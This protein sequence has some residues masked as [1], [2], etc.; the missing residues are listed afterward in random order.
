MYEVA[1]A[2][3]DDQS[4]SYATFM[5]NPAI[6]EIHFSYP[7]DS[8]PIKYTIKRYI[9]QTSGNPGRFCVYINEANQQSILSDNEVELQ[10]H[11]RNQNRMMSQGGNRTKRSRK[12]KRSKRVH[13]AKRK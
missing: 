12:T 9:D 1:P 7:T 8:T 2:R 13:T 6:T 4:K 3:R 11:V 10:K 5:S